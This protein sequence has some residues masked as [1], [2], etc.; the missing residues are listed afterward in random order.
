M[1]ELAKK[2]EDAKKEIRSLL[3]SAPL[4]LT[5]QE[6]RKDYLEYI[7]RRLPS[8]ELGY[9]NDDEFLAELT[10]V[11]EVSWKGNTMVLT[12]VSNAATEHI[13][14]LVANQR[15]D[16]RKKRNQKKSFSFLAPYGNRYPERGPP[17]YNGY[18]SNWRNTTPPRF[19]A[20]A[21]HRTVPCVPAP[22]QKQIKELLKNHP[23]GLPFTHFTTIF[24]CR[25]GVQLD[26]FSMGFNSDQEM[27]S[28]LSDILVLKEFG[29]H[30][31]NECEVRVVS[32]E[33]ARAMTSQP[34]ERKYPQSATYNGPVQNN[35]DHTGQIRESVV[36]SQSPDF[37]QKKENT[38]KPVIS[39][40][41]Q[42][43]EGI[44][45]PVI[46]DLGQKREGITKPVISNLEEKRERIVKPQE[47]EAENYCC[48][49]PTFVQDNIREIISRR[50]KGIFCSRLPH[51]YKNFF[52]KELPFKTYGYNSVIEFVSDLPHI[53]RIEKPHPEGG[54]I[55][56]PAEMSSNES[57]VKQESKE[58]QGSKL[59]YLGYIPVDENVKDAIAQVL[60]L[61][62]DGIPIE[63]FQDT[64]KEMTGKAL[65]VGKYGCNGLKTL[66]HSLPDILYISINASDKTIVCP[67]M[68]HVPRR[69]DKLLSQYQPTSLE[70]NMESAQQLPGD[71]VSPGCC[72]RAQPLPSLS[73][74]RY[75][76]LYVS[77][78]VSPSVFWVQ[79]RGQATTVALED[80][81][82]GLETVY[83]SKPCKDYQM[84][85]KLAK[86]GMVCAVLFP[87][88]GF[89]YRG[90][91]LGVKDNLYE[92]YYVDYGN[93]CFLNIKQMRILKSKFMSLPAQAIRARLSHIQ[94]ANG[95]WAPNA[96]DRLLEL[97]REKPLVGLVTSFKEGV[98]SLCLSDTT[99]EEDVHINDLMVEEGYAKF[100][101][102]QPTMESDSHTQA[103]SMDLLYGRASEAV[104]EDS[105]EGQGQSPEPS[106]CRY[107][108]Q[109]QVTDDC[110]INLINLDG[111]L[112]LL[113]SEIS[114]FF[115]EEDIISAKLKSANADVPK[116]IVSRH[117]YPELFNELSMY[118]V[119]SVTE[120]KKLLSLFSLT[121]VP[122][123]I[124]LYGKNAEH[125]D[126]KSTVLEI[127]NWFDPDDPYWKGEDDNSSVTT[128]E[129]TTSVVEDPDVPGLDDLQLVLNSLNIKR[130]RILNTMLTEVP[131]SPQHVNELNEV[132]YKIKK[133]QN[134]I[135]NLD[136][137]SPTIGKRETTE[138]S[139]PSVV[140]TQ[141]K[142]TQKVAPI[143]QSSQS[144]QPA[145]LDTSVLVQ[146]LLLHRLM[147]EQ[148]GMSKD[149]ALIQAALP[150]L[151]LGL[152][153]TNHPLQQGLTNHPLQQGLTTLQQSHLQQQGLNTLGSLSSLGALG[154]HLQTSL[155]L[156][157]QKEQEIQALNS[158]LA[159][160]G[161]A[162]D[163]QQV[164]PML[165]DMLLH[166]RLG[167]LQE[168][169]QAATLNKSDGSKQKGK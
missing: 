102:D 26:S 29:D 144:S 160:L 18:V 2:K 125:D 94:P 109:A 110:N 133:V 167:M 61:N 31:R 103:P 137:T 154:Q 114:S 130:K 115:F 60:C 22:V 39:D 124:E 71:A 24:R 99:G 15:I 80:L 13:H 64:F 90:I 135:N 126:L 21:K 42:K 72:F 97:C 37:G 16:P 41:G 98:L 96:R 142:S 63:K 17:A 145:G 70:Q 128:Q 1:S 101:R 53:I 62:P 20:Q 117:K 27:L 100:V 87:E 88:D 8:R 4:G 36:K 89:W 139:L 136:Q 120:D 132:E 149:P 57:T 84:T 35:R 143:V 75:I 169:W 6:L 151:P 69:F 148:L 161:L 129:E 49:I 134:L 113:S 93:T 40:L 77:N 28:S 51:E 38:T 91:I 47:E 10:D 52:D 140:S 153:L 112:Y 73:V 162:P 138:P 81:M 108:R 152:G 83:F 33:A 119:K 79:V 104:E 54:W 164:S 106:P 105:C 34:H 9:S 56:H 25:F 68:D 131:C 121:A 146:Q 3:L 127:L 166:N 12:A 118:G 45:K 122:F 141:M 157:C 74:D 159:A 163:Q 150:G 165:T 58:E 32:V 85:P 66:L 76:E 23:E 86:R 14:R 168:Q 50:P 123:I 82:D 155:L 43:R 44:T 59:N 19:R 111:H 78:V 107:V 92:V 48:N 65:D 147:M 95:N 30:R 55:L 7:G 156:Q 67:K 116:V 46:S 5:I 158:R 11:V